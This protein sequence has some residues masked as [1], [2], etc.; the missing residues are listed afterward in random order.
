MKFLDAYK[1]H[2]LNIWG[3]TTGNEPG[4]AFV[5]FD[6]LQTMGWTPE[7]AADWVAN[8][9]GPTL[10]SSKFNRTKI[11]A[12]D[13]DRNALPWWMNQY[14]AN[15]KAKKYTAGTAVHW[16]LDAVTS[17][18]RLDETQAAF[19]DKFILMTEACTGKQS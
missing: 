6:H 13:D 7:T 11:M 17:P 9:M 16:Y 10:A 2:N 15:Q 3:I 5:P 12:L 18:A 14:F 19:A 8:F 1:K 4:N